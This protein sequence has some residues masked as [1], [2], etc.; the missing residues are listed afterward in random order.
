MRWVSLLGLVAILGIAW[1]MSFKRSEVKIRPI[2]WGMSLQF[3]FALIIFRQDH[4]SFIGMAVF[5]LLCINFI[6]RNTD[7]NVRKPTDIA[8]TCAIGLAIGAA[9][10]FLAPVI[11]LGWFF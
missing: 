4:L 1:A 9:A 5:S 7:G 8:I 3:L 11:P 10:Y 2:A 6:A